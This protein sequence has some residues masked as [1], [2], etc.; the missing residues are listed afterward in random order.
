MY[1]NEPFE[2][3]DILNWLNDR[4]EKLKLPVNQGNEIRKDLS[5]LV[6]EDNLINQKVAQTIF[7]NLG[8]EIE[9]AMD[10]KEVIEKVNEKKYDIIFTDLMMPEKDGWEVVKELRQEGYRCLGGE[11]RPE[12]HYHLE[13]DPRGTVCH[14]DGE[15][16]RCRRSLQR[17]TEATL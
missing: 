11:V 3:N 10:G 8:Y 9:I 7:K 13:Q 15:D 6:A 2:I 17:M 1:F 5:I 12:R 4:F 16:V 14:R